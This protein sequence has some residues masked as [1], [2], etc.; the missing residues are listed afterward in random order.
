MGDFMGVEGDSYP[1][2]ALAPGTSGDYNV[3]KGTG[4]TIPPD[5][6]VRYGDVAPAFDQ[7]GGA[8]QWVV[9]DEY[10]DTIKIHTLVEEGILEPVSGSYFD[11]WMESRGRND[12]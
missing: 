7:P 10:G 5:W 12:G 1:G 8:V 11:R 2:R 6:E 4:A 3:F 9:V